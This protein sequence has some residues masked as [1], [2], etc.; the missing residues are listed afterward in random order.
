MA[1]EFYLFI[2]FSV[3]S[4]CTSMNTSGWWRSSYPGLYLIENKQ[5]SIQV[6][7]ITATYIL[8]IY[9][10]YKCYNCLAPDSYIISD[11]AETVEVHK[12][13]PF[14]YNWNFDQ[15]LKARG[16]IYIKSI[17]IKQFPCSTFAETITEMAKSVGKSDSL[18]QTAS[19]L[20]NLWILWDNYF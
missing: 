1:W 7:S 17:H 10:T 19:L 15:S 18:L 14:Y 11:C 13:S 5:F 12:N 3:N 4:E 9:N 16:E 20:A 6:C 8:Y 2:L